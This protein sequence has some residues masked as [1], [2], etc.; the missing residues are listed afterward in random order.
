MNNV[1]TKTQASVFLNKELD[2][3][4]LAQGNLN[5]LCH[6]CWDCPNVRGSL[7]CSVCGPRAEGRD[8]KSKKRPAETESSQLAEIAE[9]TITRCKVLGCQFDV[10]RNE[11]CS[12]HQPI[13]QP[14]PEPEPTLE[15]ESKEC[16][17]ICGTTLR[18]QANLM[19]R[20]CS[21]HYV[22][23]EPR[24]CNA[25]GCKKV[26]KRVN[27]LFCAKHDKSKIQARRLYDNNRKA[28][29]FLRNL[30]VLEAS[31]N[32]SEWEWWRW[33]VYQVFIDKKPIMYH[34]GG[35]EK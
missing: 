32:D 1:K 14:P 29:S 7:Y 17:V 2:Y 6:L 27:N 22:P 34:K 23:T 10:F 3:E 4:K 26:P 33:L 16:C 13:N 9:S 8:V 31:I 20:I 25:T 15:N 18:S 12:R 30:D 5:D 28:R 19:T 35:G 21:K 24:R 11:L